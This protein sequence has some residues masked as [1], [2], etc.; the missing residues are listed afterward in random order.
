MFLLFHTALLKYFFSVEFR[1]LS[2]SMVQQFLSRL[3]RF[4]SRRYLLIWPGKSFLPFKLS[5]NCLQGVSNH[6]KRHAYLIQNIPHPYWRNTLAYNI[7]HRVVIYRLWNRLASSK[8][9][10]SFIVKLWSRK[11]LCFQCHFYQ[12]HLVLP[13]L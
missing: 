5:T 10:I 9:L 12:H 4:K 11:I 6:K 13:Q 1:H 2:F 3:P 8:I 7:C